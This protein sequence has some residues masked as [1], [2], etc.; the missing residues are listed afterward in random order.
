MIENKFAKCVGWRFRAYNEQG[1]RIFDDVLVE[2]SSVQ[3]EYLMI[4]REGSFRT[5]RES[6]MQSGNSFRKEEL[7]LT[8]A[9]NTMVEMR[10]RGHTRF[11]F[12]PL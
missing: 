1:I 10:W 5:P 9:S 11:V 3:S 8:H 6:R 2:V 12:T 7:S 4:Q